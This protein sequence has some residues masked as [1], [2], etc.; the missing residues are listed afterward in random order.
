MPYCPDCGTEISEDTRFCPNCGTALHD[1]KEPAGETPRIQKWHLAVA[2]GVVAMLLVSITM[3]MPWYNLTMRV[4]IPGE[5]GGNEQNQNYYL[6]RV[7][8]HNSESP[9]HTHKWD[10]PPADLQDIPGGQESWRDWSNTFGNTEVMTWVALAL[11]IVFIVASIAL[12][13]SS[14]S[15]KPAAVIAIVASVVALIAPMYLM[16]KTPGNMEERAKWGG[17]YFEHEVSPNPGDSFFGSTE[18]E[19]SQYGIS[20]TLHMSWGGDTG[21]FLA[22]GAFVCMLIASILCFTQQPR[23]TVRRHP[24]RRQDFI[25]MES[26]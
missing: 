7:E 4:N 5:Q 23:R 9:D 24:E 26:D 8:V 15:T 25:V 13:I 12:G 10:D 19:T 16:L 1:R 3:F 21:W 11:I 18:A 20:Y 17:E 14:H 2:L 6:D 22:L